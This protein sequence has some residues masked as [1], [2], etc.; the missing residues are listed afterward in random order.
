MSLIIQHLCTLTAW[1]SARLAGEY[2]ADS[3][4]TEGFI[5][6]SLPDQVAATAQRYYRGV[7]GM[8]LLTIDAA[9]VTAPIRHEE[10]KNGQ[11]YPHIYGPLNIDAVVAVEDYDTGSV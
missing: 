9:L 3:L 10:A 1:E 5:H 8:V 4:A 11:N 7:V 2:R 6:S